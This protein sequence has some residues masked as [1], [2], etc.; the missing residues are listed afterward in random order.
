MRE[1]RMLRARRRGL[2]WLLRH[3]QRK[4]GRNR[5]ARPEVPC[6]PSTLP[7][8]IKHPRGAWHPHPIK[9]PRGA[10]HPHPRGQA[11]RFG[12]HRFGTKHIDSGSSLVMPDIPDSGVRNFKP[13]Q[14]GSVCDKP[15]YRLLGYRL[16]G[17]KGRVFGASQE[18][19]RRLWQPPCAPTSVVMEVDRPHYT[20]KATHVAAKRTENLIESWRGRVR[21]TAGHRSPSVS[22]NA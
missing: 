21:N 18:R 2:D 10:W 11:H 16:K 3:S 9:H 13:P 4:R 19:S 6:Q 1:I 12:A 5:Q 14:G 22:R 8:A 15:R 7:R 17:L 20:Q